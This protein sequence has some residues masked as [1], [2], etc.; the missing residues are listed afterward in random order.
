M[1][2]LN[3]PHGYHR[4]FSLDSDRAI[5]EDTVKCNHHQAIGF[6]QPNGMILWPTLRET[7]GHNSGQPIPQEQY[8]CRLCYEPICPRCANLPCRHYEKW[9]EEVEGKAGMVALNRERLEELAY[10]ANAGVA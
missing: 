3:K 10:R 2:R 7:Y 1:Q 4:V 8:T 9:L 6:V 5:E